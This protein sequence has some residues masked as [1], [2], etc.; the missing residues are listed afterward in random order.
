MM[1][2]GS[3]IAGVVTRSHGSAERHVYKIALY[4]FGSQ[5]IVHRHLIDLAAKQKLPLT[6]CAIL[7]TP[8]YRAIMGEVLPVTEVLDVFRALPRVPVG[9]DP[10]CLSHYPGSLA[11]DL[12]A[13]KRTHRRRDGRWLLDRGIDYYKLYKGFLADRG[14]THILMSTIETPDEKIAAAAAR[15][16]GLGVIALVDLRNMT[17]TYF[18]TDCYET[19]PAYAAADS[20]SRAQAIEFIRR[21]R[22]NPTPARAL[23]AEVVSNDDAAT[24]PTYLPSF[25]RRAARFAKIAIERPDMFDSELLRIALMGYARPLRKI[26][27]GTRKRRNAKQYDIA[28]VES[29]PKRF[30]FYPLQYTPESSINTPAPYFVDQL[31]VI[32]ALRFAI[33][34]DHMLVVKE[35]PVCLEMRPTKFMRRLRKLPGVAIINVSVP[36]IQV[37][38]RAA[39][40]ATVTGTTAYEAFLLGRPAIALGPGLSAWTI[41][42][43]ATMADLRTQVVN[44]INEPVSEDFL[45][46][47]VAKLISV[48]YPFLFDTPHA[49]GEQMLRL[50]NIQNFLSALLD[51]LE[52]ERNSHETMA[53]SIA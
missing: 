32:D 42:R 45:I 30:V 9:G 16:L 49:A 48:R 2:D 22:G 47:Q 24:L 18:S 40:T 52:R 50:H 51:H 4:G 21:F 44:A 1:N 20:E 35:H 3:R 11:E 13:Q 10:A 26:V 37:M 23:P 15:E 36:S 29:L 34:S 27:R 6:W 19:P 17:G 12:A 41:G 33:P 46:D 28:D 39:L 43:T 25:W 8:H 5:S 38:K 53:R 31:R 7:T 14:A